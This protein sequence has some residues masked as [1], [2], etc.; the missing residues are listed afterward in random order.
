M[1]NWSAFIPYVITVGITPG[2][3]NITSMSNASKVGLKKSYFFNLGV[4]AGFFIVAVLCAIFCSVL[5]Q[6]LPIIQ[7]PM[8]FI[9][10]VY[11]LFLAYKIFKSSNEIG[12]EKTKLGFTNALVLQFINP[13]VY[14]GV[15]VSLEAYVLPVFSNQYLIIVLFCAILA[16]NALNCTL[17][18][19]LFGSLFRKILSKYGKITNTIMALLL[20]YCA[21]SLFI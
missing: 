5:S 2:P 9:G 13:K 17:C 16:I 7:T 19:A 10:A 4:A 14:L 3:N 8:I 1:F 18:W 12:E 15:I 21:I 6:I 20:V 11:M